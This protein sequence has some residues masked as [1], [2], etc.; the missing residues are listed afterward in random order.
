MRH[1]V[2]NRR[3]GVVG[4]VLYLVVALAAVVFFYFKA[5]DYG[6]PGQ[7]WISV[8]V[9]VLF[10]QWLVI[11]VGHRQPS[12]AR[13]I[14]SVPR[15]A[16]GRSSTEDEPRI[17]PALDEPVR[18]GPAPPPLDPRAVAVLPF[19]VVGS[20][21]AIEYLADGLAEEVLL[22]LASLGGARVTARAS[23]FS[24]REE[25]PD[26]AEMGRQLGV[27][28]VL[29][30]S[31]SRGAGQLTVEAVL[32]KTS[33]AQVWSHRAECEPA[34][35]HEAQE[36]LVKR[37]AESLGYGLPDASPALTPG[38]RTREAA[39]LEYYLQGRAFWHGRGP[40]L[41]Q[42]ATFFAQAV[43]AD[44][45][46][47]LAWAGR[48]DAHMM[49]G[50]YGYMEPHAAFKTARQSAER[51]LQLDDQIA[52]AWSAL[53]FVRTFHDWDWAR[54]DLC[55]QKALDLNPSI[56]LARRWY[57][58]NRGIVGRLADWVRQN[59]SSL[60]VDPL[61]VFSHAH[62]AWALLGVRAYDEAEAAVQRALEL[63]E[64]FALGYW[65]RGRAH[66]Y[67]GDLDDAIADL[68]TAARLARGNPIV[69]STLAYAV[70]RSGDRA[71]AQ[72]HLEDLQAGPP[73]WR[74]VSASQIAT[75]ELGL[76]RTN[77]ALTSLERAGSERDFWLPIT[78]RRPEWDGVRH[79]PR[80]KAILERTG[81]VEIS[82]ASYAEAREAMDE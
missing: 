79:D 53:G 42:S 47:A 13:P 56:M 46:F 48:A 36:A 29:Q 62:I 22:G 39:A 51:A 44:A 7:T 66:L 34:E 3:G 69:V 49:L 37:V 78:I 70:A 10:G 67:R 71:R 17:E 80:F 68:I 75:V 35:W 77:D 11:R 65:F 74:W 31:L 33:G 63:D 18:Q 15:E 43:H 45:D 38:R 60:A 1:F 19:R 9:A 50:F 72:R 54:A 2:L 26:L 25:D 8:L 59:R 14:P 23:S 21:P 41:Q 12:R 28:H 76:D 40:G 27:G 52:E 30:G 16:V 20:D 58:M 73:Q 32:L 5:A 64:N 4:S 55:F 57:A 24:R 82:E 6:F 81:L 61:A